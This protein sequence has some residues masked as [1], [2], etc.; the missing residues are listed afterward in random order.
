MIN[1][2]HQFLGDPAKISEATSDCG[3]V[4]YS[5]LSN[6]RITVDGR[7]YYQGFFLSN[8]RVTSERA[9][10]AARSAIHTLVSEVSAHNEECRK[11]ADQRAAERHARHWP[12]WSE[13]LSAAMDD[14]NSDL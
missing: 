7:G 6:D 13:K 14:P 10:A 8:G 9:D 11:A 4:V 12:A 2:K 1:L 5:P 3:R